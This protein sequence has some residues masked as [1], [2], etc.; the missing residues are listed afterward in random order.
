MFK[1][2]RYASKSDFVVFWFYHLGFLKP[3]IYKN[4]AYVPFAF[5]ALNPQNG[6]FHL[7]NSYKLEEEGYHPPDEWL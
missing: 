1:Q 7:C 2:G 3:A 6:F 5:E 4:P